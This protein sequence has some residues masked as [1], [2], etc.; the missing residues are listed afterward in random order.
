VS[1]GIAVDAAV[2]ITLAS[3]V[4]ASS[5]LSWR[6]RQSSTW[7]LDDRVAVGVAVAAAVPG[8]LLVVGH[9]VVLLLGPAAVMSALR[10]MLRLVLLWIVLAPILLI[11]SFAVVPL[12]RHPPPFDVARLGYGI[13]WALAHWLVL[14]GMLR[15]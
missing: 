7:G 4:V 2:E 8:V 9:G 6:S 3:V 1:D 12:R 15:V 14:E 10:P 5:F 13:A 11:A